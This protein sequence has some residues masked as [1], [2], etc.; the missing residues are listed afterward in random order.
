MISIAVNPLA[1]CFF[2][3][4]RLSMV[5]LFSP[6]EAIKQLPFHVRILLIIVL[7]LI[8]ISNLP[9]APQEINQVS[10]VLSCLA[11]FC[12]G[13]ILSLSLYASFAVF[14]V[15]GQLIDSQMGLNAL[16]LFN[17]SSH[18]H[19]PISGRLLSL[20]AVL[21]FFSSNGHHQLIQSLVL[22]FAIISPGQ[23]TL[24]NDFT[25]L[26]HH[27]ALLFSLG[28]ML[29]SPI[30]FGLLIIEFASGILTRNMPQINTYFLILPIKI[31]LGYYFFGL[32]LGQI[33]AFYE[34][35]FQLLFL[36]FNPVH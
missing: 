18:S 31:L 20:L 28:L 19:D 33:N 12:N 7:S 3:A 35:N 4:I 21:F 8:L 26:I 9:A 14:Q 2:V 10:I 15:A 24:F 13:L 29:A 32:L 17:P 25:T 1:T 23:L 34:Y 11:E 22:S 36:S 16:S 5:L 30:L 27:Y 6:I